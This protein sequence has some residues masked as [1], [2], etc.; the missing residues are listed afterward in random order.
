[1]PNFVEKHAYFESKIGKVWEIA[2]IPEEKL[3]SSK[4]PNWN[5]KNRLLKNELAL[6][7]QKPPRHFLFF[8]GRCT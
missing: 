1:M 8:S 6:P 2:E 7:F 4:L 3:I 5:G